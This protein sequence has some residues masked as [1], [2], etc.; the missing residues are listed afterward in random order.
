[1]LVKE[2][3]K[4]LLVIGVVLFF[5]LKILRPF[6]RSLTP[7]PA[8]PALPGGASGAGV[9][10]VRTMIDPVTGQ[11]VVMPAIAADGVPLGQL[12][13]Q[14]VALEMAQKSKYEADLKKVRELVMEQPAIAANVIKQ[15]VA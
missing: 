12:P 8:L 10:E 13:D 3:G 15:W 6:L 5:M 1:M 9:T 2:L 4:Q 7:P 14:T 11:P